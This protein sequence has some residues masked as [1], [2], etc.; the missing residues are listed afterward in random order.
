MSR[1]RKNWRVAARL[2]S[3]EK[4][5]AY[6]KGCGS[7]CTMCCRTPRGALQMIARFSKCAQSEFV[8]IGIC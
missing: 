8:V 1:K 5:K 6:I 2:T 3:S 7:C 4:A